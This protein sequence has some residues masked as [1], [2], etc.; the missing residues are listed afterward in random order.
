MMM[1]V[2]TTTGRQ[3]TGDILEVIAKL[4]DRICQNNFRICVKILSYF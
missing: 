2:R 3:K 4:T 1:A